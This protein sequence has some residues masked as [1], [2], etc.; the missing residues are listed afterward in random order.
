MCWS[1]EVLYYITQAICCDILMCY[2]NDI[3]ILVAINMQ[4]NLITCHIHTDSTYTNM[5]GLK[6][7][8]LYSTSLIYRKEHFVLFLSYKYFAEVFY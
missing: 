4:M 2:N 3:V 8:H 5:V 7:R 6:Y 1:Y